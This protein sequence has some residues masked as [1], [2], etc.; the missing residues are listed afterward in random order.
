M[1]TS[2]LV[3]ARATH[4]VPSS[5]QNP[6]PCAP[7][8]AGL[9]LRHVCRIAGNLLVL[10]DG[11]VGFIDFGIVG[12]ISPGTWGAMQAL[13]TSAGSGDYRLMAK[14]LIQ[15]GATAPIEE[16]CSTQRQNCPHAYLQYSP[17]LLQPHAKSGPV[18]RA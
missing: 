5:L 16:A 15:M 11:R 12:R 14:A 2:T 4:S 1:P 7:P 8:A 17:S 6:L 9:T 10:A 13:A 3:T 18:S